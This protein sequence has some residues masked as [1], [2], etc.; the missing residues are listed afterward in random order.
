[1]PEFN[2]RSDS[3]DVEKIME[4]VRARIREKRGVDYT[5]DQ[6]RE[7]AT[8]KLE[9]FLDPKNVRSDLLEH[10]RK[11]HDHPAPA[12]PS[13]SEPRVP[14]SSETVAAPPFEPVIVHPFE[15][16]VVYQSSRGGIGKVLQAI[17]RTLR[18]FLKL[19]FNPG[20]IL[21]TLRALSAHAE[22]TNRALLAN[23]ERH[24]LNEERHSSNQERHRLNDERHKARAELDVLT[25]E[26]LNNLVVEM[27]RLAIDMKNH[28]MR[29]ESVA[30][31][32]DFDERRARALEEV[33]QYRESAG[34]DGGA[35]G[36]E[37]SAPDAEHGAEGAPEKRR[38]RRRRGRRRSSGE[39]GAAATDV[40]ADAAGG[41]GAGAE[42]EPAAGTDGT[43]PTTG[44]DRASAASEDARAADTRAPE[45]A[46]SPGN[47]VT[48]PAS[49]ETGPSG[50]DSAPEAAAAPQPAAA[51]DPT[52]SPGGERAA[53]STDS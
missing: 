20:P 39:A 10:Y 37:A 47:D 13:A 11:Q 22:N 26:V 24:V 40:T 44:A 16:D 21:E 33:V 1:M 27:T 28:K 29:V 34:T 46:A 41:S 12:A 4:Q 43:S 18:P 3:I 23:E 31:R 19:L 36:R 49:Q 8:V 48:A 45:P 42:A 2:I 17:R 52:R 25:Y 9:R 38:R 15:P 51:A 5:E 30:A 7:L 50:G 32:L 14:P 6:I 35:A 53:D